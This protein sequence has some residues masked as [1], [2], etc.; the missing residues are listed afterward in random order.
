MENLFEATGWVVLFA[1]CL[2]FIVSMLALT[3]VIRLA[4]PRYLRLLFVKMI[5]EVAA[6]GFFLFYN[7]TLNFYNYTAP[8]TGKWKAQIKWTPEF[9]QTLFNYDHKSQFVPINPRSEGVVYIVKFQGSYTGFSL[10][11]T[12][13][14]GDTYSKLFVLLER[15]HFK[16]PKTI[17]RWDLSTAIRQKI[18]EFPYGPF[19]AYSME[20]IQADSNHME[21][22]M[23]L[24]DETGKRVEAGSVFLEKGI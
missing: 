2:T 5:L 3:K 23:I 24:Q 1:F 4:D 21:G 19:F 16:D 18:K 20:F 11:E 17:D 14:G 9:S 8:Y 12:K 6:A 13:N 7:G 22:K 15:F 10:W